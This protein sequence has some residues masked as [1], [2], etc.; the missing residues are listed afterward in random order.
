MELLKRFPKGFFSESSPIAKPSKNP[1]DQI[2]PI[3]W[4]Q[5][6]DKKKVIVKLANKK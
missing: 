1:D 5:K 2:L 3:T 4:K 6:N